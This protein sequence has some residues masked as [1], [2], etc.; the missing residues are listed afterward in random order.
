VKTTNSESTGETDWYRATCSFIVPQGVRL[1]RCFEVKDVQGNWDTLEIRRHSVKL[2]S[3]TVT[4]SDAKE[5][6]KLKSLAGV[7]G[8][9]DPVSI[10]PDLEGKETEEARLITRKKELEAAI[11]ALGDIPALRR[12]RDEQQILVTTLSAQ[13][14]TLR[15][16][17]TTELNNPL[18][19][20]CKIV[21]KHSGYCLTVQIP[22]TLYSLGVES[23]H[24]DL[25]EIY[26]TQWSNRDSQK[27]SF[28]PIENGYYRIKGQ[29][30]QK[31]LDV[32]RYSREDF[33]TIWQFSRAEVDNQKWLLQP[34]EN[35]YYRIQA[36]HSQKYLDVFYQSTEFLAP[37]IQH[38]AN[39]RDNQKWRIEK[40]SEETTN[41]KIKD[42]YDAL[43]AKLNLYNPAND[44]LAQLIERLKDVSQGREALDRELREV[45]TRLETLQ[46][47]I[48]TLT[49]R[50]LKLVS[51]AKNTA[52]T[53][54]DLANQADPRGLKVQ[55]AL[56]PFAQAAS[57]LHALESCTGRVTLSYQDRAGNLRQTH[58]DS[59]YDAD[60]KG[61]EWLPEGYRV[62]LKL[63]ET[64][65]APRL[66]ATIFNSIGG[67]ITIEFWAKG[68][69]NLPKAVTFLGAR[70]TN[71]ATCL[72]IQLPNE[73]GQVVWEA[74]LAFGDKSIDRLQV[75][76]EIRFYRESWTHWAFVKN[77]DKGEMCIYR[78]GKLFYKN[79][80][81]AKENP[82][83]LS[84]PIVGVTD[85]KLGVF[86]GSNNTN[87]WS[88][89]ITELRIWNVAL[90][91]RELET[92]SLLTLSGNEPGLV[93]YYPMDEAQG[94]EIRDLTGT[95][96]HKLRI[97]ETRWTPCTAPIGR[98]S[99]AI[100]LLNSPTKFDGTTT[101]VQ[102][103]ALDIDFSQ[104][105]TI[106]A[107][108]R[109]EELQPQ[110]CIVDLGCGSQNQNIMLK[111]ATSGKLSLSVIPGTAWQEIMTPANALTANE[112]LH[113]AATIEPNGTIKLYVNGEEKKKE[114]NKQLPQQVLRTSN[115]VGK[116]NWGDFFKGEMD[117]VR[118]WQK[119]LTKQ[120]IESSCQGRHVTTRIDSPI[121]T[122]YTR[123]VV[124]PQRRK[125]ATMMRC[126]ALAGPDGVRLYDEQ[127]IEEL[128]MKW[129]GNAQIDPTL[130]GYIEGAPP[131]P[132]ENLTLE[133]NYNS[134]TSVELIQSSDLSYSWTREQD[135]SL[136]SD[137]EALL[138]AKS[139]TTAGLGLETTVEDTEVGFGFQMNYAYHWQNASR[140]SAGQSLSQSNRLEL[141]GSQ[142]QDAHFPLLGKRFVPKN[143]GYALV[144]S[145]LADVFVSKLRKS[146]RMVGYQVLPVEGVPIDVNTITFLINPAYTMVGSLD[147]MTGTRATSQRVFGQVPEMRTQYG[148]LY[149]ASY[150]RLQEAYDLK[151]RIDNQ[152]LQHQAYFNQFN[153]GL[154]DE[155]SLNNQTG[156][157][158]MTA[159][160]SEI[161]ALKQQIKTK[162][163]EIK[164]KKEE[165]KAEERKPNPD[166]AKVNRLNNQIEDLEEEVK[167]LEEQ[168]QELMEEEQGANQAGVEQRQKEIEAAHSDLSAREHA[169]T[170]FAAWQ[171]T[172]ES[173]QV[174]AGKRNI[175]N[176]YIWDADGGFHAEE[177]Q[178]AS[179]IEHSIGGSFD[180]SLALGGNG[181]VAISK[182]LVE[183]NVYATT[184]L[185]QTMSKTEASSKGMELRVNLDGVECR[186]ITDHRDYPILPGEKVDRYRFMSF[187]LEKD[188]DHWHDFF[189]QVVDPEW[190]ASNDEEA[191]ALRQTQN[192]LPNEVWR[193]LH[194]V[195]Y[196]E[197]PALMGF[198]HQQPPRVQVADEMQK[199]RGQVSELTAKLESIDSKLN[200]LLEGK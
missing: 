176:T 18:N 79:D 150:F 108:V 124:D 41:S 58:Y 17:Y 132:S 109:L 99:S 107:R 64:K 72:R 113:V 59:A 144:T 114:E 86:P 3:D 133:D 199:L 29:H 181:K 24:P 80:P 134:A 69:E 121:G 151:K 177:Q 163:E 19:Y 82:V 6:A 95:A 57:R 115:F 43:Q 38:N 196:V 185:T 49:T 55:G 105:L 148:S 128:E 130:I 123:M 91:E 70:N 169:S 143:V 193:V 186:G 25:D 200:R 165:K 15:N 7:T 45:R 154:V 159:S 127:R 180:L 20:W 129:I 68:S 145:G 153:A 96:A 131:L 32:A 179:T 173:L 184:K 40:V 157:L 111:H 81:K 156:G 2:V 160:S 167:E 89:Q 110:S 149:P 141:R 37:I 34:M 139:Q 146:G 172:M 92:N 94:N 188:V 8:V 174:R 74:G 5:T 48:S 52:Q 138:G 30:S 11:A 44:R 100:E 75:A 117:Y 67:Q 10:L 137:G 162:N 53:M 85:A 76:T 73:N 84:Q 98:F 27:W 36:K 192:A 14:N 175:V 135:A 126:L 118:V 88:G 158:N 187:Y 166:L 77:C 23:F 47:E 54:T 16:T 178:F 101:F 182:V 103:P 50:Y 65:P 140:V 119:A 152:D 170:S 171:R 78:N 28:E 1:L 9:A 61:E 4:R 66:P 191:R 122:E 93:A 116:N 195:T 63:D 60:G 56:L 190:L 42:A 189:N 106:E 168:K 62:A 197:R 194:R 21:A 164:T 83:V 102:L 87:N 13:V 26:Q 71:N 147:G 22:A 97:D 51:D 183:L 125:T 39:G 112:W 31:Y 104:G 46:T 33:A 161:E 155:T 35:G 12:Q 90:G 198:G 136:G 142:E 120:E